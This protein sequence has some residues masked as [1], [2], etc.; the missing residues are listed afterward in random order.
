MLRLRVAKILREKM[1]EKGLSVADLAARSGVCPNRIVAW[2][3]PCPD[4]TSKLAEALGCN[5]HELFKD[6]IA[7]AVSEFLNVEIIDQK[8]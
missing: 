6:E 5:E 7:L 1:D 4:E 2:L 3:D 8:K